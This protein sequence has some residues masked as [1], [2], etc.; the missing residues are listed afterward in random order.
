MTDA[1]VL[2]NTTRADR[3]AAQQRLAAVETT[4]T[5]QR[6][7]LVT[8]VTNI[9]NPSAQRLKDQLVALQSQYAQLV[10]QDYPPEHPQRVKLQEEIE[11]TKSA[12]AD[13]ASVVAKGSYV[14]DPIAQIER[15]VDQSVNLQIEVESMRARESALQQ[16]LGGYRQHLAKLP[17]QEVDLA[18]LTLDRDVNARIYTSLLERREEVR[19]SE[20]KQIPNTRVIDRAMVPQSPI[21]PRK[22]LNLLLGTVVGLLLG[23]GIGL[24]LE[25]RAG[26]LGSTQEFEEKTGWTVLALVPQHETA[27]GFH[28]WLRRTLPSRMAT[29]AE[30][31][32][33]LVADRNPD[34]PAGAAYFMLRTRLELLGLGTKYRSL[35]VTSSWPQDGKSTTLSNLA[36]TFGA[37]GKAALVIDAEL[38]RPVQH[39]IFGTSKAP[40]LS[41]LLLVWNGEEAERMGIPGIDRMFQPTRVDGVTLLASGKRLRETQWE[42]AKSKLPALLDVLENKYDVALMDSASPILVHDTLTLCGMVDAVIVVVNGQAY[43]ENRLM[44]TKR[45]LEHAGANIIGAVV[46]KVDPGGRYSFYYSHHYQHQS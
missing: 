25:S 40:G 26:K 13:Q 30:R 10:V 12:L 16:T 35:L 41:D 9:S 20:A 3:G 27:T 44:E 43:D 36:A 37:A 4:L 31:S 24:V 11:Q 7:G 18:R 8:A 45:L 29:E 19:I 2:L 38:R 22:K 17:G 6:S 23:S 34:S 42:T 46:N 33:A 15:R 21:K 28:G 39:S 5:A 14:G 32:M 1:E